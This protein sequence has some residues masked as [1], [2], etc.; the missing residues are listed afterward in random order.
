LRVRNQRLTVMLIPQGG[1]KTYSFQARV[2]LL[3]AIGSLCLVLLLLSVT[4][5]F[6]YGRLLAASRQRSHLQRLCP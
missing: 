5:M 4:F 2:E 6:S 3:F 1:A